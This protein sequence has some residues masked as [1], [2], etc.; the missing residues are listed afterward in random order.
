MKSLKERLHK[1]ITGNIL[2]FWL[3]CARDK[4][5][6]GCV[7]EV[8]TSGKANVTAD[9]SLVLHARILWSCSESYLQLQ[10]DSYL[11]DAHHFYEFMVYN[12]I[13]IPHKG[14]Y[15]QISYDGLCHHEHKSIIAQAYTIFAFSAYYQASGN[16][17][18]LMYA[19]QI[20]TLVETHAKNVNTGHYYADLTRNWQVF[21]SDEYS[22]SP[23]TYLHLIESYTVLLKCEK[24]EVLEESLIQL[25][26]F[27]ITQVI[28]TEN[29]Y[30]KQNFSLEG[31]GTI[32]GKRYG[33]DLEAAYLLVTAAKELNNLDLIE[34]CEDIAL[35]L[36]DQVIM[37]HDAYLKGIAWGNNIG[38]EAN[39]NAEDS[40][41]AWVQGEALSAFSWAYTQTKNPKY[42]KW[43]LGIWFYIDHYVV[44]AQGS[45]WLESREANG[46]LSQ[47]NVQVGPWKCPYHSVRGCMNFL[48][49]LNNED[50]N[51]LLS[52]HYHH[53]FQI[54]KNNKEAS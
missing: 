36:I 23:G 13:D 49:V 25:I 18:A 22:V 29:R 37:E 27:F 40:R 15:S 10:K 53:D 54:D 31:G 21:S 14:V 1:E 19:K 11:E 12:F 39:E 41:V 2:P 51:S 26:Q 46:E 38:S 8:D 42:Q 47:N 16:P 32:T 44:D 7:G 52:Q 28:D 34:Q 17:L 6:G 3:S 20:F 35:A 9:K 33:H 43:L 5:Y 45:D 24:S 50:Q 48:S 30:V 4:N